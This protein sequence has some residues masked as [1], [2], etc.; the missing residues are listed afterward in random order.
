[1]AR[2]SS[3]ISLWETQASL[4]T[5]SCAR[6]HVRLRRFPLATAT[7][8]PS[9]LGRGACQRIARIQRRVRRQC[10]PYA[11]CIR[12]TTD[13][14]LTQAD[15][16]LSGAVPQRDLAFLPPARVFAPST[17]ATLLFCDC[18]PEL[19]RSKRAREGPNVGLSCRC[20]AA[21][22]V[23]AHGVIPTYVRGDSRA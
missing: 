3:K 13:K 7:L 11:N 4:A 19:A 14:W 18:H 6:T 12:R 17:Q 23:R 21:P 10:Y 2:V 8:R 1:R 9:A 5:P 16:G 22:L 20:S 15:S